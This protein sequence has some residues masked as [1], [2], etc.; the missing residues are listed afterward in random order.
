MWI[1]G[2]EGLISFVMQ[3]ALRALDS[4]KRA[5]TRTRS[6]FKVFFTYFGEIGTPESFTVYFFHQKR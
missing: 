1:L 6:N 3:Y 4:R 5:I 2:L